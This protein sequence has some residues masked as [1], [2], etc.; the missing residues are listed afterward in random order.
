MIQIDSFAYANNPFSTHGDS[1][2]L[3]VTRDEN[4]AI[5]LLWRGWQE[6]LRSGYAQENWIYGVALDRVLASLNIQFVTGQ[7]T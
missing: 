7:I 6:K 3:I 1:G 5:G 4:N 2:S